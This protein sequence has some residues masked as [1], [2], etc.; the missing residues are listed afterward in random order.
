MG[1]VTDGDIQFVPRVLDRLGI[2]RFFDCVVTSE[3]AKAYKPNPRIYH[4]A[5]KAMGAEP[6]RSLF[7]SDSA[8]DLEGAAAVG[9]GTVHIAR[10]FLPHQGTFPAGC[11]KLGTIR[12]LDRVVSAYPGSARSD[13][14]PG[15][16]R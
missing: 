15:P 6:S 14:R 4:A 13:H 5:L 2:R 7:V 9:M 12:E 3:D 10:R 11:V 8:L 16:A 1:V